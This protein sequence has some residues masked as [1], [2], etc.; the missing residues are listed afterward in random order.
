MDFGVLGPGLCSMVSD[1]AGVS[2][3]QLSRPPLA[4]DCGPSDRSRNMEGPSILKAPVLAKSGT[5][6]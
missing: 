5:S 6:E 1:I 4:I 3:R 2:I